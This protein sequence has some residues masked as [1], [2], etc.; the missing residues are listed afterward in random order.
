[1]AS[2]FMGIELGKKGVVAHQSALQTTG[3]NVTNAETEGYSRQK[4]ILETQ[5]P[6]YDPSFNRPERAGHIGQGVVAARIERIRNA[7]IDDRIMGLNDFLGYWKTKNSHLEEIEMV[8]NE[9]S[10]NSL[11]NLLNQF[12]GSWEELSNNPSEAAIRK[13]VR[14]R[15]ETLVQGLS[16]TFHQLKDIQNK[17]EFTI[18][19]RV[20]HLNDLSKKV[21]DLNIDIAKAENL[22]D[23]PNDLYDR[24]DMMIE[25][26]SKLI[27]INVVRNEEDEFIVY[28]QGK[29]LIQGGNYEEISLVSNPAKNG[30]SDLYWKEINEKVDVKGGE[31]EGL[32]DLRDNILKN[33]I[34][35]LNNF[36]TNLSD[37]VNEVHRDGFG[38]DSRTNRDFFNYIPATAQVNGDYDSNND[39]NLNS[40]ALFKI[41]GNKSLTLTDKIGISGTLVF[42]SNKP[43]RPA[44]QVNYTATDTVEN[45]IKKINQSDSEVVA[46]LDHRDRLVVKATLSKDDGNKDFLIRHLE[47]S[48]DFFVNYSG[49]LKANGTAGAYDW[50]STGAANQLQAVQANYTITPLYDISS[51][52][53]LNPDIKNDSSKIAAAFGTDTDGSGDFDKMSGVGDGNAALKIAGLRYKK[54]MIGEQST[55]D[56]YYSA[57]VAEVGTLSEQA[58]LEYE[59][60]EQLS[61]N[62]VNLRKSISGVNLDEEIANMVMYQHG[63]NASAR[64]VSVMDKMLDTIINRMGV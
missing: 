33:Q 2:T 15:S 27:D 50:K 48:G 39:G 60:T 32:F 56:D 11:R 1:M 9:P 63:Y 28:W 21:K 54:V 30:Y 58:K 37:L 38:L 8:H 64:V 10:D 24:R 16:R 14:E 23:V 25:E 57:L 52:V 36:T 19:A 53:S 35:Y 20:N 13:V 46:Y 7:F 42:D 31:L 45:V 22:G 5:H 49:I 61:E 4:V 29:H 3:H 17:V 26:I 41:A 59:T 40:T 55:F 43:N 47:D 6:L 51:W 62:L 34:D 44:I 18:Q 12:W